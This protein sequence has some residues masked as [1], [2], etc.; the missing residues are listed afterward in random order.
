MEK[1]Q[2]SY[3][4]YKALGFILQKA[5][6]HTKYAHRKGSYQDRE[7]ERFSP[8]A[9]GYVAI[10]PPEI[11]IVDNDLYADDGESFKKLCDDLGYTPEPFATTPSGGE[12]YAFENKYPD[13]V[14]GKHQYKHLDI[15]SGYQSVIPIVGTTVMNKQNELGSYEWADIDDEFIVNKWDTKFIELFNM[16]ERAERLE[17]DEDDLDIAIKAEEMPNDEVEKLLADMPENLDYDTWLSVGMALTDRFGLASDEGF[18]YFDEFSKRSAEKYDEDLTY[19]KWYQ[20]HLKPNALTFKRLRYVAGEA[21]INQA[22]CK[23]ESSS[24]KELEEIASSLKHT[25]MEEEDRAKFLDKFC[26]RSKELTKKPD[27]VKWKKALEYRSPNKPETDSK[28]FNVYRMANRYLIRIGDKVIEEVGST[29]LNEILGSYG[30][31]FSK[32]DMPK[33]KKSIPNISRFRKTVDY[34]LEEEL[35]FTLQERK[36]T[37]DVDEFVC[38][39]NPLVNIEIGVI[40]E[41]I[42]DD[43]FNN[44]WGGKLYDI[45]KLIGLTIRFKETKLNRLMLVA[46]SNSGKSELFTML[47]FQK[48]HMARLLAGMRGDKGVGKQ[49]IDGLKDSEMMLIDEANKALEQDIKDL[50]KEVQLDQFGSGGTQLIPLKFTALTSTHSNATRNNSDELY[51]RFLQVELKKSE[52]KYVITES[53]LFRENSEA[54]SSSVK[55][56]LTELFMDALKGDYSNQELLDLQQK[57][58]LPLNNDLSELL[59]GF[60]EEFIEQTKAVATEH[61]SNIVVRNGEYY[62]K[63]KSDVYDFFADKIGEVPSLDVGKYSEQLTSHFLNENRKSIKFDGKVSKFYPINLSKFYQDESLEIDDMFEDLDNEE[64]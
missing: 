61:N 47:N 27:K 49:I 44:V 39:F 58:R 1:L 55:N 37:T 25:F 22:N 59:Y 7:T 41:D 42:I 51:N 2:D 30:I 38:K 19:K 18:K 13:Q 4:K 62:Y 52:M 60:S 53:P 34:L 63:R 16:R 54:Y 20:G 64:F 33:F 57:Y 9:T 6:K 43:F 3:E 32:E 8:K 28:D 24:I 26:K 31:F 40:N 5:G 21:R 29:M 23:I 45:V 46:P 48:I 12:H 15:Y 36:G 35:Q 50:D 11:I 10:I 56:K 14:I 17:S